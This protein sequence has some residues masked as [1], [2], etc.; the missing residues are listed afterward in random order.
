MKQ[1]I[2]QLLRSTNREGMENVIRWL[3]QSDFFTAPAS[4][5]F[6]GNYEG[7]LAEHSLNVYQTALDIYNVMKQRKPSLAEHVSPENI[8]IAALLHDA[9][10]VNIYKKT[11]KYRKDKFDQWETYETYTVDYN[12]F[13]LGHGEKSVIRLLQLSLALTDDEIIAIRWH[14]NAWDLPFQSPEMKSNIN[15]A[16]NKCPLLCLIQ[17]AD[18]IASAILENDTW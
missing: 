7:G 2:I 16:R 13:P 12:E 14:M 6:H 17:T 9:C 5:N 8:I 3:E 10:K 11:T 1:K 15:V 4:T 18:G